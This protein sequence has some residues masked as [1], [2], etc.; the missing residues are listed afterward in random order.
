MPK[1]KKEEQTRKFGYKASYHR[2]GYENSPTERFG[3]WEASYTNSVKSVQLE[4][5]Y[6]DIASSHEF[7][8][9]EV[10][11]LV[12]VEYSTG[13][14]FGRAHCGSVESIGLFKDEAVANELVAKLNAK[15]ELSDEDKHKFKHTTS[16]GQT[17]E[18][19]WVPWSGYFE[20]LEG[21]YCEPVVI[22][23]ECK[24]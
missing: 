23:K 8:P 21:V 3:S 12:W 7:Q 24:K 13:D 16:D 4:T 19:T 17:F 22:R 9:N 18:Y 2:S 6:P 14:S 15:H 10:A 11:F 20:T 5:K 1:K